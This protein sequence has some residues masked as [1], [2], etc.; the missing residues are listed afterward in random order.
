MSGPRHR[1]IAFAAALLM[2]G[3]IAGWLAGPAAASDTSS[4]P[5]AQPSLLAID[6][7][8]ALG[9]ITEVDA[10]LYKLHFIRNT[11]RLPKAFDLG[12]D[13]V[14]CGTQVIAEATEKM[15]AFPAAA[16]QEAQA[17]LA[18]PILASYFDTPHFRIHYSTSGA[19]MIY[20]WPNTAY[21][22][23]IAAACERSYQFCHLLRGWQVPPSDGTSGGGT[24]LIDCYVDN[25]SGIY[26]YTEPEGDGP[27]WP[28]DRTAF[29]VIDNDYS[30]FPPYDHYSPMK[31]T[32]A[33]E[34]HHVVQ[35]GYTT[36]N[37]TWM[38]QMSTFMED[39]IFDSINDNYQYLYCYFS[40]PYKRFDFWDNCY[41]YAGF[42]W[43]TLLKEALEHSVVRD[44]QQCAATTNLYTCFDNVLGPRGFTLASALA[45]WQ[46]YNF[47]TWQRTYGNHYVEAADYHSYLAYDRQFNSYPV[48]NQ[49]PTSTK[50]PEATGASVMR[51]VRESGSSHSKL[52]VTYDGPP[53][54][55]QVVLVVK[56]AGANVFHEWYMNLNG[57][58]NGALDVY[59]WN[60][61]EYAHMI[62]SMSPACG[63]PQ[64]YV[65]S[66]STT[67]PVG[68]EEHPPLYTRLVRLD[69]NSPNPFGP[70]TR[71]S[72]RLEQDLPV[73]LA[74][75]DAGGRLVRSLI[76]ANQVAGEYS[77]R[78]DGRD[79][80]GRSVSPG[81][82]FY[83][84]NAAGATEVRKMILAE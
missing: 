68:V 70:E 45:E 4:G 35:M 33:H 52:T 54:T 25:L 2:A 58:G 7:A 19:N 64:D 84:L 21:R 23:S 8:A 66:A 74:V 6:Q 30:D 73:R 27:N 37:S 24:G 36:A 3:V 78:W 76:S 32:V 10:V 44:V 75:F 22:D 31:V 14:K 49:H 83:R 57:S 43:P 82:Y 38:E 59:E 39:E 5:V 67:Q 17:L 60:T 48:S 63:T 61:M 77:V 53:C 69:Q 51:L 26:G 72:Y 47:Y 13:R 20:L 11:G 1:R 18:R 55:R 41:P 71:I 62:V 50:L 81:V 46:V 80:Q 29:F 56:E 9:T 34:Y 28:G 65:F 12:G 15:A 79:E 16:R 42:I 40:K